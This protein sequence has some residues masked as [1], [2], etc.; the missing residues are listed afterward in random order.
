VKEFLMEKIEKRLVAEIAAVHPE[1][2][3]VFQEFR[4]DI[5]CGGRFTI[6]EVARKHN[7]DLARLVAR[8]EEALHLPT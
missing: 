5:C 2:L 7:L 1:A 8:L 4:I 3:G 6:E